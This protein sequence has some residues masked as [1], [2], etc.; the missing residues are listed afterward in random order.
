MKNILTVF[1]FVALTSSVSAQVFSSRFS[2]QDI[3]KYDSETGQRIGDGAFIPA[4]AGLSNPHAILDRGSD[5]LVASWTHEIKRFDRET[6]AFL[7]NFLES[8]AGLSN[9]VYMEVGPDGN[10]YVSSQQNDRIYRY[11]FEGDSGSSVDAGPWI[12]GGSVSGPSG[13]DWSPDGSVFYVAG[14]FSANVAAY[15]AS[16]GEEIGQFSTSENAGST[17][18]L[19]VDEASGDLFV[20]VDGSVVRYDLSGGFPNNGETPP[21]TIINTSGSIGLEPSADG[22]LIH[23]ASGNNLVSIS[24]ADNS[25]SASFFQSDDGNL[26]NFFH[27]SELDEEVTP[28]DRQNVLLLIAD[29]F[30]VDSCPL[31][32]L[33]RSASLPPM[34]VFESLAANGVRFTQAYSAPGCSPTRAAI[35]TGRYGYRS[36]VGDIIAGDVTAELEAQEF[37]L[38]EAF[39]SVDPG[40]GLAAFGKWHLGGNNRAPEVIGGWP[41]FNGSLTGG[42]PAFDGW[43][44][45][46]VQD[47][48]STTTN[49][50]PVY[51]TTDNVNEAIEFID[52]QGDDSWFV[53]I[54]FNAPHNPLHK[55]PENL[56]SYD[57]LTGEES[58][59]NANGRSYYE[60]MCEALDTEIG[61]LLDSMSESVRANTNIIFVGDNGT[62][63]AM[64]QPPYPN[65]RGKDTLY[66][67]GVHV[68]L[69][70]SGPAVENPGRTSDWFAHV[71]DLYS[72]I[73]DL[74]GVKPEFPNV[75][76]SRSLFP[77]LQGSAQGPTTNYSEHFSYDYSVNPPVRRNEGG[78]T[79]RDRR[80]KLIE[81]YTGDP[82]EFFD[83]QE[84]PYETENLL[85]DTLS[86]DET[87]ALANLRFWL[88]SYSASVIPQTVK[89]SRGD[90]QVAL[91]I[92]ADADATGYELWRSSNLSQWVR[93]ED[94]GEDPEEGSV[95]L[96]DPNPETPSFYSIAIEKPLLIPPV[97]P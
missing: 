59:I 76:D 24:V 37:T 42:V 25:V 60:A 72:T 74:A 57:S 87:D 73:L 2:S 94:A 46:V 3:Y 82:D 81:N 50:F 47:G 5:I 45:T 15:N 80:Y 39:L 10:L 89:V 38:P 93:V 55:P 28:S 34:P 51:V 11:N 29:D 16:T 92:D 12:E 86:E 79:I 20:A 35:I 70:I 63:R 1:L 49:N 75:L 23:V 65:R 71:V 52:E 85:D 4:Q 66:Q 27:F 61:R 56:H 33:N 44:K 96:S 67:G 30:G 84:D 32:N 91:T 48:T 88:G 90:S 58:D 78:R 97:V 53:W 41:Y 36:G 18:G 26:H 77:V 64:L 54:G 40:Y 69:V 19:A 62:S 17:F 7:G 83:L 22:L 6:G 21:S 31:Y 8:D 95:T 13:F 9:P 14:R 43:R 68:P